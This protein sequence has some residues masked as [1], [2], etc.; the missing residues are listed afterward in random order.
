MERKKYLDIA[1]GITLILVVWG[2]AGMGISSLGTAIIQFHMPL[3]FLVSG[4]FFKN[5][6]EIICNRILK[7]TKHLI[8]PYFTFS[9]FYLLLEVAKSLVLHRSLD[10]MEFFSLL[11]YWN[12]NVVRLGVPIWFLPVLFFTEVLYMLI[13]KYAGRY[14]TIICT[15]LAIIA[16]VW[17]PV[18]PFGL[19]ISCIGLLF[20]M[21]GNRSK[22]LFDYFESNR[23]LSLSIGIGLLVIEFILAQ[24]NQGVNLY[25][26]SFGVSWIRYVFLA[27]VGAF[28]VICV[29]RGIA[30]N[31]LLE[32]ISKQSLFIL[33]T[34]FVILIVVNFV[35]DK[36]KLGWVKGVFVTIICFVSEYLAIAVIKRIKLFN[37]LDKILGIM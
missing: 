11:F 23:V 25:R 37:T 14:S 5:T 9:I 21:I 18:L 1:K 30:T 36:I 24:Y 8:I 15:A 6:Q 3:F 32:W 20:F 19:R 27:I 7:K 22:E 28:G 31:R 26:Y 17:M 10:I 33:S 2:H 13:D 4:H 16:F 34:H 12:G 29:G 35:F